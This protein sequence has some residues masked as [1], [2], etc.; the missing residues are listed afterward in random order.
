MFKVA[1][2]MAPIY[3]AIIY[4]QPL[5]AHFLGRP[6]PDWRQR[7]KPGT[8]PLRYQ[9]HFNSNDIPGATGFSYTLTNAQLADHGAYAVRV[10]DDNGEVLSGGAWRKL[11]DIR[12]QPTNRTETV[13][14]PAPLG[15]ERYYRIRRPMAP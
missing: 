12:A 11:V 8:P 9:W 5:L 14:D 10:S 3:I 2:F 15:H 13:V 1:I 4:C 6:H 7:K